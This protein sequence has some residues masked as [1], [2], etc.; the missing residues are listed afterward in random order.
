MVQLLDEVSGGFLIAK[1]V[2]QPKIYK[3]VT[4]LVKA[5]QAG[6]DGVMNTEFKANKLPDGW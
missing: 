4:S 6:A 1:K 2:R 3:P 5:G